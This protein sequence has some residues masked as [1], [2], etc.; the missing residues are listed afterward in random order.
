[1]ATL[2]LT[3]GELVPSSG[4][5]P[6]QDAAF[7][8]AS[9]VLTSD[10]SSAPADGKTPITINAEVRAQDGRPAPD[11]T[12]VLFSTTLGNLSTEKAL[13]SGGTA[14]VQLTSV[15]AGKAVVTALS[16]GATG[17]ISVT[18]S[19][20]SG[21]VYV[22]ATVG[23]DTEGDG[24]YEKPF[25]TFMKAYT[26]AQNGWA[27]KLGAGTYYFT[28][29]Y[30]SKSVDV[31]GEE[32]NTVLVFNPPY[33]YFSDVPSYGYLMFT[34]SKADF[35]KLVIETRGSGSFANY[36][37]SRGDIG[38]HNVGFRNFYDIDYADFVNVNGKFKFYN[39]T[40][41]KSAAINY[42]F[43]QLLTDPT[44]YI[45]QNTYGPLTVYGS[46]AY[47]TFVT[48]L[49]NSNPQTD[50]NFNI[51]QDGWQNTGTGVNPD[52]TQAHIGVYG[53]PYAWGSGVYPIY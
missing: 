25:K 52:G 14:S 24:S 30:F 31:I 28:Q 27:I 3:Q 4:E 50:G 22:D 6:K 46:S 11:G 49:K 21:V 19:S 10:R 33:T 39:C 48:N 13:T 41:A 17:N 47:I 43:R 20:Y 53:G 44:T 34:S 8:P 35:Y 15:M 26:V 51:L 2:G 7:V 12:E 40:F 9:I 36:F 1:M 16:G 42:T 18:F 38:F 5:V 32:L 45:V 23:S 29:N 37:F